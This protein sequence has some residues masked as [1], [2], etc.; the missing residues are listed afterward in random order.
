MEEKKA[1]V[2]EKLK[3]MLE[4]A[5]ANVDAEFTLYVMH[6]TCAVEFAREALEVL[7]ATE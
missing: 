3:R 5:Q 1:K 7:Q 2:I 4:G 6:A